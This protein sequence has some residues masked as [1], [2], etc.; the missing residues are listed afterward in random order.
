MINANA[1]VMG[2]IFPNIYDTVAPELVRER[3]MGSI[4]FASR[5][6][7][8]DFILSSMVHSG[9]DNIAILVRQNYHSMMDHVG[10]GREYDLTRK[11]GGLM[12]YPPFSQKG[13]GNYSGRIDA[14]EGIL[15]DLK[16]QKE[17][18]VIMS[19]CN[20]AMNF[21]F[22]DMI[23]AH[24]ASGADITIAYKKEPM[25]EGFM[26]SD[27]NKAF[28]YTLDIED[29]LV[30]GFHVNKKEEGIQ[31]LG[32]N[33]YMMEREWL[34]KKV[35]E[36]FVAGGINFERDLLLPNIGAMKVAAYEFTGYTARIDSIKGYMDQSLALLDEKN[37]DALFGGAQIYTKIRDDNPTRYMGH[38]KVANVMVADGCVIE[39]EVE[40]SVL[41]RGVKIG[42]GA[43]VKN[44]ILM[45]DTVVEDG[46]RL[47]H[48]IADKSVVI[49]E[50]KEVKGEDTYPV[51]I[52]KGKTI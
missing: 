39:G 31:N 32:M 9:I 7:M 20:I 5:Y 52:N 11:N 38:A 50:G 21:D 44:C 16:K 2:I 51:Y 24:A 17:K 19:D 26:L 14:L 4:P 22:K 37:L 34:I 45:Q 13:M 41:F 18:Y 35:D 28:Y 33:I 40:N 49:T 48:V 1:D 10:S 6:R 15:V 47:E 12:I 27:T 46:V 29:G 36:C 25:P 23:A 42:R 8:I 3:M 30:N 43:K